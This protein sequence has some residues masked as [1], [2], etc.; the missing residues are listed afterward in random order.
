MCCCACAE[1]VSAEVQRTVRQH[2]AFVLAS[3]SKTSRTSQ[4]MLH[5]HVA[6]LCRGKSLVWHAAP[7]CIVLDAG[8][9]LSFPDAGVSGV[10]PVVR[11][12]SKV[13][14][15]GP[16]DPPSAPPHP[17]ASRYSINVHTCRLSQHIRSMLQ[18]LQ[19]PQG[20]VLVDLLSCR[21]P[22]AAFDLTG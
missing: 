6:E 5:T 18:S 19:G 4:H 11:Q 10:Q 13:L 12:Y 17:S 7:I 9:L 20:P 21:K 22:A 2:S 14:C 1:Q 3:L 15:G 8:R 16:R